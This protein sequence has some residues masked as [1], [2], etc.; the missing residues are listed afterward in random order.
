MPHALRYA[1]AGALALVATGGQAH[2]ALSA[3]TTI[4]WNAATQSTEIVHR[5]HTHD[6]E[7]GVGEATGRPGLSV[8]DLEGRARIALYVEANFAIEADGRALALDL[9]GAEVAGDY[10]LVYQE[11]PGP[12]PAR[13]RVRSDIL[14]DAYPDQV[15][16]VNVVDG[17]AVRTLTFEGD[18]GWLEWRYRDGTP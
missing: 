12:L 5:L 2:R 9:V 7:L 10:L 14:R 3:L 11:R 17:D 13:I 15:N 18:T 8:L 6:A 16:R 1:L 4:E